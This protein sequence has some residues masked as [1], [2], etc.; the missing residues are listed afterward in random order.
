M[1]PDKGKRRLPNTISQFQRNDS[2]PL[3]KFTKYIWK[4][5][6]T[7]QVKR[8]FDTPN[9]YIIFYDLVYSIIFIIL[10]FFI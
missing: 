9:V 8:I 4:I 7:N 3:G 5:L 2:V 1:C 6:K 10:I